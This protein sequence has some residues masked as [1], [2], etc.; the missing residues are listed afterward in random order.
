MK[1]VSEANYLSNLG[2]LFF[3]WNKYS[4]VGSDRCAHVIW[5]AV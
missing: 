1:L 5:W 4:P 2:S 3:P